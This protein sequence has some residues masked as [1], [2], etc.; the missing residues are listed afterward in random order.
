MVHRQFTG[1]LHV[2]AHSR[3]GPLAY[4][5]QFLHSA[6]WPFQISATAWYARTEQNA[7]KLVADLDPPPYFVAS[8]KMLSTEKGERRMFGLHIYDLL[9]LCTYLVMI[10]IV[11]VLASRGV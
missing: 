9:T 10:T 3:F 7:K 8:I 11:G 1:T 5:P 2:P 6:K 4:A